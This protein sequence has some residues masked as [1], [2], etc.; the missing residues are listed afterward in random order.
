MFEGDSTGTK[1]EG[2][3][4]M[5]HV[6]IKCKQIQRFGDSTVRKYAPLLL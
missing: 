2:E 6:F 3:K 1:G 4:N 5:V